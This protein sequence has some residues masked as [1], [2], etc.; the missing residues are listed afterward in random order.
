VSDPAG[1]AIHGLVACR[2]VT[3]MDYTH[4]GRSGVSVQAHPGVVCD[5]PQYPGVVGQEDPVRHQQH[6]YQILEIC[7]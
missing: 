6:S 4:L 3:R 5:A 7:C 1:A 2:S